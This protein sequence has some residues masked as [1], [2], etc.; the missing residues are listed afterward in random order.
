MKK[1]SQLSVCLSFFAS[2]SQLFS[3]LFTDLL[4]CFLTLTITLHRSAGNLIR[5]GS[6]L[7]PHLSAIV[8]FVRRYDTDACVCVF[9]AC[10]MVVFHLVGVLDYTA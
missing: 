3:D 1:D 4:V 8:Y 9:L 10:F 7:L 6:H 5:V 2:L